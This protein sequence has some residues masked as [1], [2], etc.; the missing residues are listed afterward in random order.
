MKFE[1]KIKIFD[2]L[3]DL[4]SEIKS[5]KITRDIS[6]RRYPVRLIFL[7]RIETFRLL[8]EKLSFIGIENYH[9]EKDLPHQDGWITKDT[10]IDIVKKI[11]K[12]TAIVPFSEIVRFYS[13]IDFINFFNQL[14]LI[15]NEDLDRRIYL[16]LIGIEERFERD[17]YQNFSRQDES[18]PYWKIADEIPDTIKVILSTNVNIGSVDNFETINN[19]EEWLKF[20]K[21]KSP[22][23]VICY[24][25]PLNV[26]YKNTL[27]DT[28]FSIEQYSN[29]KSLIEN[30][31]SKEIPIHYIESEKKHWGKLAVLLNNDF[32]T[33]NDFVKKYLKV[34]SLTIKTVLDHWLKEEDEFG[35]WLIKHFIISQ[36]CLKDK[37]I[38][39]VFESV[40]DYSDHA[41]LKCLYQKIF[42]LECTESLIKDRFD[43]IKQFSNLKPIILC[44]EVIYE[45]SSNIR[46]IKDSNQALLLITGLFSFEKEYMLELF[47]DDRISDFSLMIERFPDIA[48]YLNESS[49][50]NLTDEN[51]WILEYI[52]EYKKSKLSNFI[53]DR[54]SSLL[55]K[56]NNDESSFYSWYHSFECIHSVFHREKVDKIFWIDAMGI[57]WIS[58]IEG[59]LNQNHKKLRITQKLIGVANLPSS[60]DQNRFPDSKYI[61]DF[62]TF[63]HNNPFIYPD[64]I[65]TEIDEVKKIIEK[66]I[67]LDVDQKIAIVSDHGLT[68]LSRLV[69]SKKYGKDDSHEG[70]FIEV[71]EKDHVSDSDYIIHKSE[72]DQK[73]YLVALRHN[74][75]GRKP[76]RE[77]HGGC[78][79]EEILVPFVIITNKREELEINYVIS[80]EK[81][82]ISKKE[83]SVL[84]DIRPKPPTGEFEINGK[85]KKLVFNNETNKWVAQVDKTLSGEFVI[86]VI[87]GSIEKS[88][89]INIISGL[90]EEDLF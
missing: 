43:L 53:T 82:E 42:L 25:N 30:V 19:S 36:N 45:L 83:P 66:Y 81:T 78:T 48:Y 21:K 10:L 89:K 63:I 47:L 68:A 22:C 46:S 44:D 38:Y 6:S 33:F 23:N 18:A 11:S 61:Q 3:E 72:V 74:S 57:E 9:L 49:F 80:I 15:E 86:K 77:V 20:W 75:L 50:E 39:K 35:K 85:L 71:D 88:F 52:K 60:T 56:Y 14:L 65:L 4:I 1:N 27:P 64:S 58:F 34:T 90:I 41:L 32:V 16:P 70:R 31:Y 40:E 59:Y 79:P 54:L 69:D 24:S 26:F 87:A 29:P 67:V 2:N 84:V 13:K 5:D 76:I 7:Q 55:L 12:N 28:I 17:F 73:N 51:K 37:Y 8:I 62:D